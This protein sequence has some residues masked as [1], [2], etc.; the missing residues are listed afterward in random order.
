MPIGPY[1]VT[2]DEVGDAQSLGVR[3]WV[4]GMM[5][6]NSNTKDMVFTIAQLISYLSQYI[7]LEPGDLISTGTPEG[8]I[9]GM[10]EKIWLKPGDVVEVEVEGFGKLVNVMEGETE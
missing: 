9:L 5:R 4:N 2:A 6:Q 8:V 1:L 3:C 10:K 7:T